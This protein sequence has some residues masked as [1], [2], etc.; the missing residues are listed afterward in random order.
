MLARLRDYA[1]ARQV[2][3]LKDVSARLLTEWCS[4]WTF[5]IKSGSPAAHWSVVKTFFRWGFAIDLISADPSA[6][7][8]SK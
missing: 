3:L 7:L 6:K 5:K 2:I 1:N 8:K 4:K